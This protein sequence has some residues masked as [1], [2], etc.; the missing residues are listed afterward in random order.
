MKITTAIALLGAL[1]ACD[2]PKPGGGGS[3]DG[4]GPGVSSNGTP[5]K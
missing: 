4:G 1:S 3:D 5:Q 2:R